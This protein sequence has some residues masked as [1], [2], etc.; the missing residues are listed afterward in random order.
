MPDPA[1]YLLSTLAAAAASAAIVL[2][3]AG[4]RRAAGAARTNAA[5]VLAVACG[6]A[7]GYLTMQ[8]R[9]GWPPASARD[10][11]LLIVLPAAVGVE[12]VSNASKT[13]RWLAWFLRL[14]LALSLARILLRG[15]VYVA[16]PEREWNAWQASLV[17][18]GSGALLAAV[19]GLLGG[20][21]QRAPGVSLPLALGETI[22]CGGFAVMLAGY[23]GGGEAAMP[24]AA[25]IAGAALASPLAAERSPLPGMI[26][27]GVVGL[28]SLLFIGRFF[29]R[30]SDGAAVVVLLAP[31]ACWAAEIPR[32]RNGNP[33]IKGAVRLL[34]TALPLVFV[35][36]AAKSR[37]D[38]EMGPLLGLP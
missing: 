17:L 1:A 38:H 30:L 4:W 25:A 29:G 24:L 23:V 7:I 35:L 15:S 10:R 6:A 11:L 21:S 19:W 2:L 32:L 14:A 22:L 13:P 27:V 34:L 16:G 18:A 8:T 31:L 33:W 36:V 12:L 28:F 3:I 26:G 9:P 37:F 5:C 20:L